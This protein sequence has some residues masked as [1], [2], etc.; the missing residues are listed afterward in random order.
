MIAG[1]GFA[2]LQLNIRQGQGLPEAKMWN[3]SEA[4]HDYFGT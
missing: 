3:V 4:W 2:S 1:Q